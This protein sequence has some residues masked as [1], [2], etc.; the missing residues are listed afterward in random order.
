MQ[1]VPA[2]M[3][4]FRKCIVLRQ[5]CHFRAVAI[6]KESMECSLI[7]GIWVC[8]LKACLLQDLHHFSAGFKFLIR[9]FRMLSQ[10]TAQL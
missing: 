8:N 2:A 1:V 4:Y 5:N 10:G 7:S 9:K 6:I 3:S